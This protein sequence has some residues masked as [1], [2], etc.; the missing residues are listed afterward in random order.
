M[1]RHIV[2][3]L[4]PMDDFRGMVILRLRHYIAFAKILTEAGW[5]CDFLGLEKH[6]Q[7]LRHEDCFRIA[8]GI[9]EVQHPWDWNGQ[10]H[11]LAHNNALPAALVK[12]VDD[13]YSRTA[14]DSD[15]F[16]T[17]TP[18]TLLRRTYPQA[19]ILHYEYGIF[20]RSPFPEVHQLDPWGYSHKSLLAKYPGL[21][22]PASPAHTMNLDRLTK[23]VID[24]SGIDPTSIGRTAAVHIPLQSEGNWPARLESQLRRKDMIDQFIRLHPKRALVITEKAGHG[25]A[26][27][28]RESL[29]SNDHVRLLEEG[30]GISS[31]SF[32]T[33]YCQATYT[34]SPSLTLQTIL[35]RNQLIT[36]SN[37]SMSQ[38]SSRDS[39][40]SYKNLASYI[41]NFSIYEPKDLTRVIS[42]GWS[43]RAT[44]GAI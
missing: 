41:G 2:F 33:A 9:P 22:L 4:D 6:A 20:S 44:Q 3:H 30:S 5:T 19:L 28:E 18:S 25:L 26:D 16:I 31:G 7:S 1:K 43:L 24:S 29:R 13:L 11:L 12:S 21:D 10:Y 36:P 38:W 17:N 27:C 15:I 40:K 34:S 23:N 42:N 14:L 39:A 37:S 35:W 32:Q 8:M